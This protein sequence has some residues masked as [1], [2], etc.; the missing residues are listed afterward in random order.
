MLSFLHRRG[1]TDEE[2]VDV[3]EYL[4]ATRPLIETLE[5]EYATWIEAAVDPPQ[6][7]SRDRDPNGQHASV[8]LWRVGETARDFVQRPPVKGAERYHE[9]LSLC[10]EA[11]GAA[12]GQF[13]EA[14]GTA[15]HNNPE[16]KVTA[17]N[18]KLVESDQLLARARDALREMEGRLSGR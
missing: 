12:A 2:R 14:S 17:A 10:L 1:L 9:A 15:G 13:K 3:Q 8:Y 16:A 5:R 18:R 11:R 7:L 6:K 4:R